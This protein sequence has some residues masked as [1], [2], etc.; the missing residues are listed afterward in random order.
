VKFKSFLQVLVLN[1]STNNG[2]I[3]KKNNLST[4]SCRYENFKIMRTQFKQKNS[5]G[6]RV[7]VAMSG[8][9]DSSVA[10]YIV[11]QAGYETIGVT[12]Q[13]WSDFACS[14]ESRT[15]CSVEDIAIARRVA[16][17]LEIPFYLINF[18]EE[19]EKEV[20]EYF[21]SEYLSGRTPNPCII[22]N[23]K[24]K[25]DILWKKAKAMGAHFLVT[26][27]YA[28]IE[29]L[30]CQAEER[31]RWVLQAG[32]D[33]QKDQSYFLFDL[34]SEELRHSLF[35][36]GE[37][38]KPEVRDIARKL[39]LKSADKAESQEICFIADGDIGRFI[40]ERTGC[41]MQTGPIV[42]KKDDSVLGEHRGLGRY[43]IGQRK[44][45]GVAIGTP[46]YVVEIDTENNRL[47]VGD[48]KDL[49]CSGI[50]MVNWHLNT[51]ESLPLEGNVKVRY[52]RNGTPATVS[53]TSDGRLRVLF[54]EPVRA[55][56]PGQAGVIYQG[57]RVIGGGWIDEAY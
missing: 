35:P 43:T 23:K 56:A 49:Q 27:H 4:V 44:G 21:C 48:E 20:V 41:S 55:A 19:F 11:K 6:Q 29:K 37:Y 34:G 52:Q 22:C 45:L 12:M 57:E 1:K 8:G 38:H 53:L 54:H 26:G 31:E 42:Y 2:D 18:R 5:N 51:D 40:E 7:V 24:L 32:L 39:G 25:F 14:P 15:C 9:V 3:A 36:L 47:V 16:G 28:R 13:I 10:A 50:V 46:L 33:K 17:Q 30:S